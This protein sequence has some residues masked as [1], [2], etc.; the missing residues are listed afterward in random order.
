MIG[1]MLLQIGWFDA[2]WKTILFGIDSLLMA[3]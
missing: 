2:V 1:R 3:V